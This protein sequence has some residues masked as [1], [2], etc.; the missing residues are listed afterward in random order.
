MARNL[1]PNEEYFRR[2][3]HRRKRVKRTNRIPQ[4]VASGLAAITIFSVG[5]HLKKEPAVEVPP[6]AYV[7]TITEERVAPIVTIDEIN[8]LNLI[9]NDGDCNDAFIENICQE[10]DA[11]GIKY[12]FS[13]NA[14]DVNKDDSVVVTLDQ[15]YM[16]GNN[17]AILG[18][19]DNEKSNDSDA[20]AIAMNGAFS[21]SNDG[22]YA[23]RRCFR[24]D[25]LGGVTTRVPTSTEDA[26]DKD[27]VAFVTLC[28]GTS[29]SDPA[30]IANNIVNG[31]GRFAAFRKEI[32]ENPELSGEDLLYRTRTGDSAWSLAERFDCNVGDIKTKGDILQAD[33]VIENP[34]VKKINALTGSANIVNTEKSK[35]DT[36][37]T[38][39]N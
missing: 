5:A 12:E 24:E 29:H 2:N 13:R 28:F 22:I 33:E 19:H 10:L 30:L 9:I 1:E 37:P 14:E 27:N 31:L 8:E 39:G 7:D 20:L 32:K 3:T 21:G 6:I 11:Q 38:L 16:S 26:I 18:Q 36:Q 4:L 25:S 34:I 17:M 15:Q 23:G 35:T